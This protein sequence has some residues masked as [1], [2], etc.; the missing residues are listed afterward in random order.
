MKAQILESSDGDSG[1]ADGEDVEMAALE[2]DADATE[3][4]LRLGPGS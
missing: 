2:L 3:T 1:A 4:Y